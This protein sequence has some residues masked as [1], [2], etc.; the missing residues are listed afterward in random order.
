MENLA[1]DFDLPPGSPQHE[2]LADTAW[3]GGSLIGVR[4][5]L[6]RIIGR[7]LFRESHAEVEER[8]VDYFSEITSPAGGELV[9]GLHGWGI[10]E[11]VLR[12]RFE[13][14]RGMPTKLAHK[15]NEK[16][17]RAVELYLAN[18]SI[19]I[20]ELA[21]KVGTTERQLTRNSLLNL[22]RW[23]KSRRLQS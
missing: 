14:E 2:L 9:R 21:E 18:P 8:L 19:S 15:L 10:A 5:Y 3:M 13:R 1:R 11:E 17:M 12:Y 23:W 6:G 4:Y 16:G 7:N 20:A 22:I